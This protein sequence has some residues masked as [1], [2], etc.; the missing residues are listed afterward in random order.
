MIKFTWSSIIKYLK[1]IPLKRYFLPFLGLNYLLTLNQYH[2]NYYMLSIFTFFNCIIVFVNFPFLITLNNS[3]PLYYEDIYIDSEKLPLL[4][5]DN[6]R[7]EVYKEYYTR[8]LVFSNSLLVSALVCYWKSK[9]GSVTSF[10]EIIGITGGLIEIA[11]CFNSLTG[12]LA[13]FLIKKII[14]IQISSQNYI[15]D[16]ENSDNEENNKNNELII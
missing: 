16:Q 5:L 11:A 4:P 6:K 9:T 13:L 2:N 1:S 7:K 12:K 8:I 14:N 3:K 15:S 10:I